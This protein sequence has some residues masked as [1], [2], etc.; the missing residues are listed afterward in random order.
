M[1]E[2]CMTVINNRQ[3]YNKSRSLP[4]FA[5]QS[6][7]AFMAFHNTLDNIQPQSGSLWFAHLV[8]L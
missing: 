1:S 6:N 8:V 4:F 5:F 3:L 7:G 2:A